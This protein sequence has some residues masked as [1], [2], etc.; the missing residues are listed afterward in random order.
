MKPCIVSRLKV[1]CE[2]DEVPISV[3]GLLYS[4]DGRLI[5]Q[6]LPRVPRSTS[7]GFSYDLMARMSAEYERQKLKG[8]VQVGYLNL[9]AFL[10][11]D[12]MRYIE[13]VREKNPKHDVVFKLVID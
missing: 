6:S 3:H 4:E 7:Q 12:A 2:L 13:V 11:H 9:V 8:V 1:T 5:A 10:D